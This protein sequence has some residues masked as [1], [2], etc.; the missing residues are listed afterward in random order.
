MLQ[1]VN[2]FLLTNCKFYCIIVLVQW[3]GWLKFNNESPIYLQLSH[4]LALDI[5]NGK[6]KIGDRLPSVR[7]LSVIFKVNPNTVQKALGELEN[8]NL[9]YTERTNGKFVTKDKKVIDDFL[10]GLAKEKT[11]LYVS[12]MK[13]LGFNKKEIVKMIERDE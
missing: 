2:V 4:V 3:G 6:Y 13:S 1:L 12:D 8:L 9:I 7:E 11:K 10:E 5:V